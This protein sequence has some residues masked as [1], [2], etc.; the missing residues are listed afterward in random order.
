ML[1]AWV[2]RR[3]VRSIAQKRRPFVFYLHPHE[4]DDRPLKSHKGFLRN[5]YVNLGRASV[6]G[7]LRGVL[8]ENDFRRFPGADAR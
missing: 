1:P 6:Y 4:F 2:I 5:V 3:S 8:E 7:K